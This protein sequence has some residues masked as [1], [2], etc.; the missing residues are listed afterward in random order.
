MLAT[1]ATW[2]WADIGFIRLRDLAW[3]IVAALPTLV[4]VTIGG[5]WSYET[6]PNR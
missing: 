6:G 1:I 2:Q 3:L 5:A 4:I